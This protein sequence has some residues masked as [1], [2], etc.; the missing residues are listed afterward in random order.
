M[1][2]DTNRISP[3]VAWRDQM[4]PKVARYLG[5]LTRRLRLVLGERLA[6]VYVHGSIALGDFSERRSD[7]DVVAVCEGPIETEAQQAIATQLVRAALPDP[8]RGLEF[9]LLERQALRGEGAPAFVLHLATSAEGPESRVIDG[10]DRPGDPD[11]LL[12]FAVLRA[13]GDT[14]V[15]P[16][17]REL[18]PEIP[19]GVLL[20]AMV[21]ELNWALTHASPSYQVLNAA[22]A[23]RFAD[24]G[25]LSS[26]TAAGNWARVRTTIGSVIDAALAHRN[27]RTE[28]QPNPTDAQRFVQDVLHRLE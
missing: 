20:E 22:R 11:L 16:P 17:A 25:V 7:I 15:G 18:F 8:G 24:E 28:A 5:E 13:H 3:A 10:T 14:V 9:H 26:K 21:H 27:G 2:L 23:W 19:R 12:H 6:G 1:A 4:N